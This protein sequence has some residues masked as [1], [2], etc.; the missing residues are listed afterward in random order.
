MKDVFHCTGERM[1]INHKIKKGH[2][3]ISYR[4][5]KEKIIIFKTQKLF[6]FHNKLYALTF[7]RDKKEHTSLLLWGV[8]ACEGQVGISI[9]MEMLT[10]LAAFQRALL[11]NDGLNMPV[12]QRLSPQQF[13]Q[14]ENATKSLSSDKD[15]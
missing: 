13:V 12:T 6:L 4:K 8:N 14:Q 7:T 1:W 9:K 3:S 15:Y 10:D 11:R 2:W 5:K